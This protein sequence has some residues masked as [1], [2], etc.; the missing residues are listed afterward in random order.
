MTDPI[1]IF[2]PGAQGPRGAL[3]EA[4]T[5]DLSSTAQTDPGAGNLRP[6]AAMASATSFVISH[7]SS[8][9]GTPD[10]S[11]LLALWDPGRL[12]IRKAA[13]PDTVIA[14]YDVTALVHGAGFSTLTVSGAVEIGSFADDDAI[15]VANGAQGVQGE[16][17]DTG[18]PATADSIDNSHLVNMAEATIKGRLNAVGSGDPQDLSVAQVLQILGLTAAQIYGGAWDASA[19]TFPGGVG[20][21]AGTQFGVTVAGTVDGVEF[22]IGDTLRAEVDDASTTTYLGNWTKLDTADKVVSVAEAIG[23]V[24]SATV[25]Q[26]LAGAAGALLLTAE[27]RAATLSAAFNVLTSL[28][29]NVDSDLADGLNHSLTLTENSTMNAPQNGIIGETYRY[30]IEQAAAGYTLDWDAAFTFTDQDYAGLTGAAAG[31]VDMFEVFKKSNTEFITKHLPLF[32][33]SFEDQVIAMFNGGVIGTFI[34]PSKT[35][36]RFEELD[37]TSGGTASTEGN[38]VG[39]IVPLAGTLDY[40]TSDDLA[41]RP[42]VGTVDGYQGLLWDGALRGL[43]RATS[44]AGAVEFSW[45]VAVHCQP[46]SQWIL[47]RGL[48]ASYW[49]GGCVDGAT[50]NNYGSSVGTPEAYVNDTSVGAQNRDNLHDAVALGQWV[51]LEIK[52]IDAALFLQV[53]LGN[54]AAAPWGRDMYSGPEI[55][56]PSSVIDAGNNRVIILNYFSEKVGAPP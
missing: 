37:T 36:K 19:G 45:F 10:L 22:D 27:N 49:V 23:V 11:A 38:P 43:G 17:G 48:T 33:T 26:I 34:D 2:T 14:I 25:A 32:P 7:T 35:D 44:I 40:L 56:I 28:S 5:L 29:G 15:F 9:A 20:T 13:Q 47:G 51:V 31:D 21:K 30:F 24:P 12:E 54:Y 46:G 42:V 6:N 1:N 16:K 52:D 50:Q 3:G 4:Y 53:H 18:D 41:E 39:T 55:L 8:G